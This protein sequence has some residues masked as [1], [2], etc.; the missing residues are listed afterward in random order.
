M[1][2]LFVSSLIVVAI[3][4][5][6]TT[7]GYA[8]D[9]DICKEQIKH[10]QK[11]KMNDDLLLEDEFNPYDYKGVTDAAEAA[12]ANEA[13]RTHRD[14]NHAE[15]TKLV[16]HHLKNIVEAAGTAAEGAVESVEHSMRFLYL[17]CKACH[18]AYQTETGIT[19]VI[20]NPTPLPAPP[21]S[22][23]GEGKEDD[24]TKLTK[25]Y[26]N[27]W[28]HQDGKVFDVLQKNRIYIFTFD[29]AA[30]FYRLAEEKGIGMAPIDK[31]IGDFIDKMAKEGRETVELKI[32]PV[33]LGNNLEFDSEETASDLRLLVKLD[34]LR[35]NAEGDEAFKKFKARATAAVNLRS[36]A[37]TE[38]K[39]ALSAEA[40]AARKKAD[41][42]E[43]KAVA[44]EKT[45]EKEMQKFA[46]SV[47]AGRVSFK[48][49]AKKSGC[50]TIALSI[51]DET[52]T[53]PLD[54]LLHTIEIADSSRDRHG[55]SDHD[56]NNALRG[57]PETLLLSALTEKNA[58]K[59]DA[60]LHIFEYAKRSFAIF[61]DRKTLLLSGESNSNNGV[62]S[63]EMQDVLSSF[64]PGDLLNRVKL[65]RK[66]AEGDNR[67][68][69][70]I[71]AANELKKRIFRAP[72][73]DDDGQ[74][75][76][77]NALKAFQKLVANS[78]SKKKPVILARIVDQGHNILF[79][80]LGILSSQGDVRVLEK[81]ITV[82]QPLPYERSTITKGC[83]NHW[84]F[85]L[86]NALDEAESSNNAEL[87][88]IDITITQDRIK[89][90]RNDNDLL[91][92]FEDTS[93]SVGG[94]GL[95]LLAHHS[96]GKVWFFPE[97]P[98]SSADLY[99]K[100]PPGSV[101]ILA[102]CS[103]GEL[104]GDNGKLLKN[105]NKCGIEAFVV[106]PFPIASDYGVHLALSFS[107]AIIDAKKNKQQPTLAELFSSAA[108]KTTNHFMK[109]DGY[110]SWGLLSQEFIIVGDQNIRLCGS[111]P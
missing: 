64:I 24:K 87:S 90:L 85:G 109:T 5:T 49:I 97:D 6:G 22:I 44:A 37:N 88:R 43:E 59:P 58:E 30:Y 81:P 65:A 61:V 70:Y 77:N 72:I 92:Y 8:S 10:Y 34:K 9:R 101:A 15:I 68:D 100:Y 89:W 84:T 39:V 1:K 2:K 55:C 86:P 83:I 63:W 51:W 52:G 45:K 95:L 4:I 26:W 23:A 110:K 78:D 25:G 82:I 67:N 98:V 19:P 62:Y 38:E 53:V 91:K 28:F 18:K 21:D 56:D 60:A 54:H 103:A 107:K 36:K 42:A 7:I 16:S 80:P 102:A 13:K 12:L 69:S 11:I 74:D 96:N 76:A 35:R 66:L 99:R 94:E 57:G 17:S 79:L 3:F 75:N 48:L 41:V 46:K 105:L 104:S 73:D 40:E 108:E 47:N 29:I 50:A 71:K 106:S 93:I 33:L 31:S 20:P 111:A 32:R 27:T 14:K